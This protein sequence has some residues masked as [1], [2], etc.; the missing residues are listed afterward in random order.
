MQ[1]SLPATVIQYFLGKVYYKALSEQKKKKKNQKIDLSLKRND[2]CQ[3]Q[4]V[5]YFCFKKLT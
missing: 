4:K 1:L 5:S 2:I 3:N